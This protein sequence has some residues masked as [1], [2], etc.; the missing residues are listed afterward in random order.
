MDN[1]LRVVEV[2]E[3]NDQVLF[4]NILNELKEKPTRASKYFRRIIQVMDISIEKKI[5]FTDRYIRAI[6]RLERVKHRTRSFAGVGNTIVQVGSVITPALISIQHIE[7]SS[8][9]EPGLIFW[10]TWAVS[11]MTGIATTLLS[12][13]KINKRVTVYSDALRKLE[14][15]GFRYIEL[16]EKYTSPDPVDAHERLFPK[17]FGCVESILLDETRVNGVDH[18]EEKKGNV[19]LEEMKN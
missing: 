15:E 9:N 3:E 4:N 8:N 1:L 18:K 13:F 14:A 2:K 10:L 16:T 17:F 5:I 11:V 7:D 6:A 19:Q 12:L